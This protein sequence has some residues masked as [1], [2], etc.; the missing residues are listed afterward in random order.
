ML[1]F[2]VGAILFYYLLYKS[3]LIPRVLP[4]WGLVSVAVVLVATVLVISGYRVPFLVYVPYVPFEWVVGTWILI[5]GFAGSA[6]LEKQ[7]VDHRLSP[8][9]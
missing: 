2:C 7:P 6:R 9:I 1:P 3:R 8:A 5:K 4:V